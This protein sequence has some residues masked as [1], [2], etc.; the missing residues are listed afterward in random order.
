VRHVK[1]YLQCGIRND[2]LSSAARARSMSDVDTCLPVRE[3][4][5]L[6]SKLSQLHTPYQQHIGRCSQAGAEHKYPETSRASHQT[7][8]M[9]GSLVGSS[10]LVQLTVVIKASSSRAMHNMCQADVPQ[11]CQLLKIRQS[12]RRNPRRCLAKAGIPSPQRV[13]WWGP[14]QWCS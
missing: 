6:L 2:L 12:E 4:L 7:H 8:T 5:T 14:A 1:S 9:D 3:A 11:H 13:V 10:T